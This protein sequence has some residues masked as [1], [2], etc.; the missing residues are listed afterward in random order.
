MENQADSSSK[1]KANTVKLVNYI[2]S[3]IRDLNKQ[4]KAEISELILTGLALIVSNYD[5]NALINHF[6]KL[7]WSPNDYVNDENCSKIAKGVLWNKIFDRDEE[8]M[9][10]W[11]PIILENL[12][13]SK[14]EQFSNFTST[15][16][17]MKFD[18]EKIKADVKKIFI[19]HMN[20]PEIKNNVWTYIRYMLISS[21]KY[22]WYSRGPVLIKQGSELVKMYKYPN[23]FGDIKIMSYINERDIKVQSPIAES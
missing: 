11:S 1:F 23:E 22:I 6:I 16:P 19:D 3:H 2:I 17:G 9:R 14:K 5:E 10:Y 12:L 18:P 15:I 13:T 8:F 21:I 4:G 20:T 7:T